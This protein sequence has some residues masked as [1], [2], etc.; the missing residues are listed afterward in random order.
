MK[1]KDLFMKIQ[2]R[3][4]E[5]NPV[6][7]ILDMPVRWSSTYMMCDRA[8]KPRQVSSHLP[9]CLYLGLLRRSLLIVL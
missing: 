2:A 1:R 4:E 5:V 6:Q 8:E 9:R 7:L 3:K